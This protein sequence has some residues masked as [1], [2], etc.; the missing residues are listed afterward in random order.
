MLCCCIH[1]LIPRQ[2][3]QVLFGGGG[4][5]GRLQPWEEEEDEED[6]NE[7]YGLDT[8]ERQHEG[9]YEMVPSSPH[10]EDDDDVCLLMGPAGVKLQKSA[11]AGAAAAAAPSSEVTTGAVKAK[12]MEIGGES[13]DAYT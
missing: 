2:Y 10:I 5:A 6:E 4:A 11:K 13:G 1:S 12:D 3:R 7:E 9:M 8:E